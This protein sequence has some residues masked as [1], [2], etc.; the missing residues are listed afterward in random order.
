MDKLTREQEKH[1]VKLWDTTGPELE[2]RR[3]EALKGKEY[4]F[5]EIEELFELVRDYDGPPR[6]AEGMVEMQRLFMLHPD[7]PKNRAARG[8]VPGK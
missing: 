7:H 1:L 4:T 5:E 6:F 2:R 3:L 8:E